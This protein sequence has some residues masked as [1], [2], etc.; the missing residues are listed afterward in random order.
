MAA[1]EPRRP[2]IFSG[3]NSMIRLFRAGGD[4]II[5]GASYWRCT[6]SEHGEGNALIIWADPVATGLSD[7]APHAIYAD[8]LAMG[9]LVATTFNQYFRGYQN[10]GFGEMIPKP[11]RFFQQG[12]SHRQH[13]VTCYTDQATIELLWQDVLDANLQF[14][15][16]TSGPSKFDVSTV[17]CPCAQ[18]SITIDGTAA[19]GEI[20]RGPGPTD[21]SA[22]LALSETWVAR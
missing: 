7:L 4:E 12:Y 16:N 5:A 14:L 19:T 15:E 8:N 2:V 6:Y 20:R 18:A 11:A 1:A 13:R 22:F 9:Q 17:I 21:S 3:E 10:R